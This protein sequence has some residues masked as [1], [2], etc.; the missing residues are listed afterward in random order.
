MLDTN[1]EHDLR[2]A[3]EAF[4]F[5]YREFTAGPDKVLARRGLNRA[6][7]RILYF[8]GRKSGIG[9]GELLDTLQ[10]S[11]QALNAP[12]RQLVEMGLVRRESSPEDGRAKRLRLSASGQ[13][14][15]A[16]LTGAQMK[17]LKAAFDGARE[18][19]GTHWLEVMHALV[20]R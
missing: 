11:K 17:L 18:D 6:H 7:H 20:S 2:Q 19:A 3:I 16:Q 14:L 5:A 8:I 13:K 10:I 12:L 15:E 4:Y 1:R 9:V